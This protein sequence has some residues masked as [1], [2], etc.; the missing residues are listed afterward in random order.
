MANDSRR[1]GGGSIEPNSVIISHLWSYCCVTCAHA[2]G[3][4]VAVKEPHTGRLRDRAG[5][6]GLVLI[7]CSP[8]SSAS[9]RARDGRPSCRSGRI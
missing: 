1:E 8:C 5:S 2:G 3:A 6:S 7:L 4:D 9:T